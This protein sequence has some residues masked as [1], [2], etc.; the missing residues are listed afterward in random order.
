MINGIWN[1]EIFIDDKKWFDL[2]S[3]LPYLLE[4]EVNPLPSDSNFR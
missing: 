1:K 2:E 3:P 4:G